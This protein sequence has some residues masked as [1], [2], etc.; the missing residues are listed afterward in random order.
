MRINAWRVDSPVRPFFSIMIRMERKNKRLLCFIINVC[1][2]EN[3]WMMSLFV[4]PTVTFVQWSH[5]SIRFFG[6]DWLCLGSWR[7]FKW[8]LVCT[9]SRFV[10]IERR[11]WIPGSEPQVGAARG[12]FFVH[13]I[14]SQVNCYASSIYF[15]STVYY[16]WC[17]LVV[18]ELSSWSEGCQFSPE[19][20]RVTTEEPLSEAPSY[21]PNGFPG[22]RGH[23]TSSISVCFTARTRINR[24]E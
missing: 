3:D 13:F 11:V 1:V 18:T 17:R 7:Y 10:A 24:E 19:S 20:R 6:D 5:V 16:Y 2:V 12:P 4:L 9:W 8:R 23:C 14:A 22:R 15:F 21:F